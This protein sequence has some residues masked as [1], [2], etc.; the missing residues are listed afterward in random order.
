[1][2]IREGNSSDLPQLKKL[3][4]DTW[5]Q[6]QEALTAENW[7]RLYNTLADDHTFFELLSNSS[8]FVCENDEKEIIGMSFL[9]PSGNPT[10]IYSS[11]QCYIRF[12]TVSSA[13]GGQQL[14]QK[15]TEK[16]IER[17]KETNES[18]IALHT[19]EFMDKARHVYEKLGFQI[20]RELPSRLGK[21]YWLYELQLK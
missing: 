20:I 10:E 4:L 12:V 5:Q 9:V 11:D 21:R 1:M 14:G 16:C 15:L 13:Y 6:Y 8:S 7:T 17:A 19:S 2:H 3:A 18:V